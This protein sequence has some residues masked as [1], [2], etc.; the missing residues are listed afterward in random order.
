MQEKKSSSPNLQPEKQTHCITDR[1]WPL[2][3]FFRL[4]EKLLNHGPSPFAL[5]IIDAFINKTKHTEQT[6]IHHSK[7]EFQAYLYRRFADIGWFNSLGS[8]KSSSVSS[9][10]KSSI[11]T[12]S[13]SWV[14]LS[15]P[16]RALECLLR[17]VLVLCK[18][19]CALRLGSCRRP[20]LIS[21]SSWSSTS[22]PEH[23]MIK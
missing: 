2:V 1:Y 16:L 4:Q 19:L 3:N 10:T 9:E 14:D 21:L 23:D 7:H 18:D 13:K 8:T 15:E 6:K 17:L 12:T 5:E 22:S 11:F 20:L